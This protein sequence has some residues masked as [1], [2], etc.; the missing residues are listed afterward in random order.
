MFRATGLVCL[1]LCLSACHRVSASEEHLTREWAGVQARFDRLATF[2]YDFRTSAAALAGKP[3][4]ERLQFVRDAL[5]RRAELQRGLKQELQRFTRAAASEPQSARLPYSR[6]VRL[7]MN[8]LEAIEAGSLP[9]VKALALDK[10]EGELSAYQ[11]R[12]D[13]ELRGAK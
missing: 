6:R 9:A 1:A 11:S 3:D 13:A 12:K 8:R 7:E 5:D 2:E 4:S 10:Y